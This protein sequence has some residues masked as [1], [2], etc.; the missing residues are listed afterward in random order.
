MEYR[1]KVK[2][3]AGK[4]GVLLARDG[5]LVVSVRAKREEGRANTR[6]C[7]LIAEYFSVDTKSVII[8]HGHQRSSKVV[9][10]ISVE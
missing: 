7:E 1:I 2:A 6:A 3:G 4:E 9:R 8:V 10:L 5:R